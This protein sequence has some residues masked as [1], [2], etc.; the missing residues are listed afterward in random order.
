MESKYEKQSVD[1]LIFLSDVKLT[2][3]NNNIIE[4]LGKLSKSKQ[5]SSL[6]ALERD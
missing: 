4:T 6:F 2:C 5:E 1:R 3:I